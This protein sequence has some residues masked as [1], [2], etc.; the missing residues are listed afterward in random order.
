MKNNIYQKIGG[1]WDVDAGNQVVDPGFFDADG[2][3]FHLG[4]DSPAIDAGDSSFVMETE[5]TDLD[6]NPRIGNSSVDV[7]AYER[8]TTSLHPADT[9]GDQKIS[10]SEFDEYNAAWRTNGVWQTAPAI[11]SADFVTRAGY[12]LQKGGSYKNIGVG[13]PQ[14]WVP[15]DD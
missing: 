14:T 6:G 12:L 7:G 15:L 10:Q 9:N 3:D 11:I 2:G 4:P 8:E 5:A 1:Y 13:K